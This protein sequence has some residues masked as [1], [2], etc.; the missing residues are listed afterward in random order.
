M[1][2][3]A[4][5]LQNLPEK[6]AQDRVYEVEVSDAL[7]DAFQGVGAT[8]PRNLLTLADEI[9]QPRKGSVRVSDLQL[10]DLKSFV[11]GDVLRYHCLPSP[12]TAQEVTEEFMESSIF[13]PRFAWAG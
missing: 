6:L 3:L 7:R 5:S 8:V 12:K 1:N 11:G 2:A 10:N 13:D 9:R 4:K